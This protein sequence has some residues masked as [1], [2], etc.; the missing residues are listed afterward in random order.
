MKQPGSAGGVLPE[1]HPRGL[2]RGP[3]SPQELWQRADGAEPGGRRNRLRAAPGLALLPARSRHRA[4]PQP[5]TS[6]PGASAGGCSVNGG[7]GRSLP[8]PLSQPLLATEHP[9]TSLPGGE[10]FF[11]PVRFTR[12]CM[13]SL[14]VTGSLG[15][16]SWRGG[17]PRGTAAPGT[18][19]LGRRPPCSS[20]S[21]T[22]RVG[23]LIPDQECF[24]P[25]PG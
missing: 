23:G 7:R 16:S 18:P 8:S 22:S 15:R 12:V 14:D 25:V 13:I 17:A 21:S 10:R 3:S 20:R 6:L 11:L 19:K 9:G 2:P 24:R 1:T 4:F 5:V